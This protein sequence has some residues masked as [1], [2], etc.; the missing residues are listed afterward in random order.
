M[1]LTRKPE[2]AVI[3]IFGGG[4]DLT[5]RKLVPALYDIY[6][7]NWLPDRFAIIGA[8][9]VDFA[10]TSYRKRL[11]DGVG[12]FSRHKKS[13]RTWN[14]F[15]SAVTYQKLD[16]T[17]KNSYRILA[18]KIDKLAKE[19]DTEVCRIFYLAIPPSFIEPVSR[20]LSETG[21]VK[22]C[23]CDRVVIEKPFG[24][25]YQSAHKLNE[26]M[27]G[28]FDERSIFRIDH[29]LG[30]ETVQNIVAFRFA[31]A[32]FEPL[33]NRN[34]IDHVQITVSEELGVG[35]RGAYYEN[36]GALR[37]MVQNHLMQLL[38]LT[39]MEPSVVFAPDELRDRKVDVLR[40]V[41]IY[42]HDEVPKFAVRGQYGSGWIRRDAVPGYR[43]EKNVAPDSST[44]TF[45]ALKLFIDNWRWQGVPFYLRTGKRLRDTVSMIAIQFKPIPHQAFPPE[46]IEAWQPNRLIISIQPRK[47]ILLRFQTKR[48]GLRMI[49][50]PVD[51]QFNY[52]DSYSQDTPDAY[53]TLLLDVLLGDQTLFMRHDQIEAAWKI[54]DP[55]TKVWDVSAPPD[56]PDYPAGSWGPEEAQALI[57][58]DGHT[59]L[60]LPLDED[61]GHNILEK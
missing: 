9:K 54:I 17:K 60:S 20:L 49:L 7:E 55:I 16:F 31:N 23:E 11:A 51:M 48:P 28:C 52:S 44:E 53:E 57:A 1:K 58:Q 36:A 24:H 14:E 61:V 40:A 46:A 26:M 6:R 25:D 47:K 13:A 27:K 5:W 3:T 29:Y 10:E 41:R 35:H 43:Q 4:G 19:W 8:D 15:A 12:K 30:K 42:V 32:F 22:N 2:P 38:C 56:F 33:W 45:A 59:W 37:D 18:A 21:L 39:A 34:Y 50:N